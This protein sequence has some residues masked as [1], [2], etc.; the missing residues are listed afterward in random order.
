MAIPASSAE[1]PET[2]YLLEEE[3]LDE[4]S[5]RS[6]GCKNARPEVFAIIPAYNEDVAIGSVVLGALQYV[7]HV[8]V[9]DDCSTDATAKLADLAGAQVIR[10]P[11]NGGKAKALLEGLREAERS[12]CRVAVMLDGDGQHRSE[13][14]AQVVEPVLNG[15]ADLVIGSRFLGE[16]KHI[17]VYRILGQK[18]INSLS[19]YGAK[20]EFTDT[21]S[22]L[23]A[24]SCRALK[25]LDFSSDGYNIESDMITHFSSKGLSIVEVPI[26]VRYDVPNGHKKGAVS[27]GMGLL[28]NVVSVIGYRRPLIMFGVPGVMV[29][30][31]GFFLGFLTTFKI[32]YFFTPIWQ[33]FVAISLV[34]MGS[35]FFISALT[36]NSLTLLMKANK[37]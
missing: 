3:S 19:N 29:M 13:D 8:I 16:Q 28:G 7:D 9:V 17:P 1:I 26:S 24:L 23:R 10:M 35:F 36:L 27:M 21:Q 34:L 2:E 5:P 22:G 15:E 37:H 20:V 14:I 25:N 30:L 6:K 18:I 11:K 4:S 32:Y 33:G 12:G 31:G